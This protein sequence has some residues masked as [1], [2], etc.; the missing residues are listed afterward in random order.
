MKLRFKIRYF[1]LSLFIFGIEIFIAACMNDPI[2]RPYGGD[3]LVV[4]LLYCMVR[5]ILDTPVLPTALA[6]LFFAY[7]IE[8]LQYFRLA[9]HL[10]L[11]AHSLP[12]II[13]GDYF[14]WTDILSYTLGII[15]V[16]LLERWT[17]R[18]NNTI[19][20]EQPVCK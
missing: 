10:G 5:T 13:L 1:L 20:H 19:S 12:R 17:G 18:N 2:I 16:I 3:F 8:T 9:D 6:V 4:I 11:K 14:T 15:C 7:L